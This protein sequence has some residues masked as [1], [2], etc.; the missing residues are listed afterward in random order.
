MGTNEASASRWLTSKDFIQGSE[1]GPS[2]VFT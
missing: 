2:K 1:K